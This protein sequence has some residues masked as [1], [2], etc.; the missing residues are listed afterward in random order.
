VSIQEHFVLDSMS[1]GESDVS[2]DSHKTLS[3]LDPKCDVSI[4]DGMDLRGASRT[5]AT[6]CHLPPFAFIPCSACATVPRAAMVRWAISFPLVRPVAECVVLVV[7]ALAIWGSTR[8]D[9]SV[10]FPASPKLASSRTAT[11][12]D[13]TS[14]P[15]HRLLGATNLRTSVA[16]NPLHHWSRHSSSDQ[17]WE[18][19]IAGSHRWKR[20]TRRDEESNGDNDVDDGDNGSSSTDAPHENGDVGRTPDNG[21]TA[22]PL[23]D[24]EEDVTAKEVEDP[25][26]D[27]N[28][29]DDNDSGPSDSTP[30]ITDEVATHEGSNSDRS[31]GEDDVQ[32]GT[33]TSL[34]SESAL[35]QPPHP[36]EEPNGENEETES[37]LDGSEHQDT[38]DTAAEGPES[39]TVSS[40]E[41]NGDSSGDDTMHDDGTDTDNG[42]SSGDDTLNNDGSDTDN[43]H[44]PAESPTNHDDGMPTDIETDDHGSDGGTTDDGV[45]GSGESSHDD[46]PPTDDGTMG[47]GDSE[48]DQTDNGGS[49]DDS[50]EGTND[51]V[52]SDNEEQ[53]SGKS[54][55]DSNNGD[56]SDGN[57]ND[58]DGGGDSEA[59]DNSGNDNDGDTSDNDGD[60]SEISV[61]TNQGDGDNSDSEETSPSDS[62]GS[63]DREGGTDNARDGNNAPMRNPT[64]PRP[65]QPRPRPTPAQ[66]P[67]PQP[68]TEPPERE[69]ES[70]REPTSE[71][72][73][74]PVERDEPVP[75]PRTINVT[76]S[77]VPPTETPVSYIEAAPTTQPTSRPVPTT[78]SPTNEPTV[79]ERLIEILASPSPTV[80]TMPSTMPTISMSPSKQRMP[81]AAPTTQLMIP[82][83]Q[84]RYV[85]WASLTPETQVLAGRLGYTSDTWNVPGTAI[86]ENLSFRTIQESD[87]PDRVNFIT[88]VGFTKPSWDCYMNHYRNFTWQELEIV[89]V[90]PYYATLGWTESAWT[91]N[92]PPRTESLE[93][94]GLSHDE[95]VAAESVCYIWNRDSL[96][97][98]EA[99]GVSS[100]ETERSSSS[101]HSSFREVWMV[102]LAPILATRFM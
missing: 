69:V 27:G 37:H 49:T 1:P 26:D 15:W 74:R 23:V 60:A 100:A 89:G 90:Q 88:A 99:W 21:E 4:L 61:E 9:S 51:E 64:N 13:A 73:K 77:P 79:K 44:A 6:C 16:D 5:K 76:D 10:Q 55:G 58:H 85:A 67:E 29:S 94:D 70:T 66:R 81:T 2:L 28:E 71:P 46:I 32:A 97:N 25:L 39:N 101:K 22:D 17:S 83:P 7:M 19:R 12:Q 41:F 24:P 34:P 53:G 87:E 80:S 102:V 91:D 35:S 62:G 75:E 92:V 72:T 68:V 52:G 20:A 43:T 40:T 93:W 82:L 95:I 57:S 48:T 18:S 50:I 8:A 54:D 38:G 98:P 33:E 36:T 11:V 56:H 30:G 86:I 14:G 3:I 63:E 59:T 45:G 84:F 78:A 42:D 65:A 31:D 96:E 47:D